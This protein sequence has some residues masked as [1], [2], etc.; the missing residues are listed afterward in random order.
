M[1][2]YLG[3]DFGEKRI[4]VAISDPLGLTAQPLPFVLNDEHSFSKLAALI[5]DYDVKV[6]VLGLPKDREGND[7]TKATEVRDF[8]AQLNLKTGCSIEFWDERF[9]T[10]AVNRHLI[11]AG[12]RREN[13][14]KIVDSQAA[15]FIL[16]GFMDRLTQKQRDSK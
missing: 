14:K 8:A 7:S 11:A 1:D 12:V 9:S 3:L 6:L 13:R 10:V 15:M 5:K 4:G 2:R 16:Q